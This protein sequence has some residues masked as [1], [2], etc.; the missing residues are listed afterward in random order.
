[1]NGW[2]GGWNGINRWISRMNISKLCKFLKTCGSPAHVPSSP[3]CLILVSMARVAG[4]VKNNRII[5][6]QDSSC[7][8]YF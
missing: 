3:P 4:R 5:S 8:C 1:M 7:G 6:L 2:V